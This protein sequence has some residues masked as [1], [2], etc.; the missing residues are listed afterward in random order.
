[1]FYVEA[2]TRH[3][4]E[5]PSDS[6]IHEANMGPTWVLSA[7]GGPHVGPMNFAIWVPFPE[8]QQALWWSNKHGSV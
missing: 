7:A 3:T 4:T 8:H 2:D 5:G 6:E 1:M